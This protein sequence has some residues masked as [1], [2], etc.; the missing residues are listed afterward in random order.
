MNV[1][2]DAAPVIHEAHGAIFFKGDDNTVAGAGHGFVDAVIG[3][4]IKQVV[5]SALVCAADVHAGTP[6]YSLPSSENLDI[7]GG[8]VFGAYISGFFGF[9]VI[10]HLYPSFD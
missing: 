4:F 9:N 8:V 5:E 2:R 1:Y 10:R 3:N 7:F 6:P